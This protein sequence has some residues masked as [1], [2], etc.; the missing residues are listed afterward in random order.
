MTWAAERSAVAAGKQAKAEKIPVLGWLGRAAVPG[1][2][3]VAGVVQLNTAVMRVF[4]VE[5]E[6]DIDT[7]EAALRL[8]RGGRGTCVEELGSGTVVAEAVV[9]IP[10]TGV[11]VVELGI[12]SA[13]VEVELEIDKA[14]I[15]EELD[16]AAVVEVGAA[17]VVGLDTL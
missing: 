16:T 3:A 13:V 6:P 15:V 10:D 5:V 17:L 11:A 14:V 12:G 8:C 2:T 1:T 4:V 7:V 9:G